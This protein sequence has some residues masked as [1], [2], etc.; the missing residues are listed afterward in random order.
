[1]KYWCRKK[2]NIHSFNWNKNNSLLVK[3][4][5]REQPVFAAEP[6]TQLV[7]KSLR[8]I[9]PESWTVLL[10]FVS[11]G[12]LSG[13]W[14]SQHNSWWFDRWV[15]PAY[16]ITA[17]ITHQWIELAPKDLKTPCVSMSICITAPIFMS[18]ALLS[19]AAMAATV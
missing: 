6:I 19:V 8:A 12:R 15:M 4:I 9:R 10:C 14:I 5:S 18:V 1:L 16:G 2:I 11:L 13:H 7:R 17:S 3:V